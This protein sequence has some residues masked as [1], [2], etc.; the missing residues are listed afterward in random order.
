MDKLSLILIKLGLF[1]PMFALPLLALGAKGAV[2]KGAAAKGAAAKGGAA[3]GGAAKGGGG[4]S[5]LFSGGGKGGSSKGLSKI[6]PGEVVAGG[7]EFL[8]SGA[9]FA[10]G[11]GQ[12]RRAKS[13]KP[14]RPVY[15]VSKEKLENAAMYRNALKGED[16]IAARAEANIEKQAANQVS[17]A[18]KYATSGGDVLGMLGSIQE[19]AGDATTNLAAQTAS[20]KSANM[21]AYSM[22][23]KDV[24]LEKNKQFAGKV[25][26]FKDMSATKSALESAGAKNKNQGFKGVAAA[27]AKLLGSGSEGEDQA[28]PNAAKPGVTGKKMKKGVSPNTMG[29]KSATSKPGINPMTMGKKGATSKPGI[30]GL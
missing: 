12:K 30:F 26:K 11:M 4:L 27:T 16:P 17:K 7:A 1:T 21:A 18:A 24:A 10:K 15:Q 28:S 25:E 2:A 8:R 23:M 3:K 9:Q 22:A 5:K 13:I 6:S 29:K 20:T 14:V 19:S